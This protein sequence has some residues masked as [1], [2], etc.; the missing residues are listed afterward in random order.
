MN[1]FFC[2]C[3]VYVDLSNYI[4]V[5]FLQIIIPPDEQRLYIPSPD[6][7]SNLP[8]HLTD[9]ILN[10]L[11]FGDVIRTSTLSEDWRYSCCRTLEVK[12]DQKVWETPEDLTFPTI[13]FIPILNYFFRFHIRM[14]L[15]ATLYIS[16]L[17]VC[18]YVDRLI[19]FIHKHFI[20]H[21]VLNIHLLIHHTRSLIFFI[22]KH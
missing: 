15:N 12:F 14:I 13:W 16:C 11:S 22:V 1:I 19:H 9:D 17:K 6:Q 3:S 10:K 21:V 4:L 8:I 5:Y 20:Q 7:L 18:P 2:S